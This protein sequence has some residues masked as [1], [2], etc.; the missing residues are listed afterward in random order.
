MFNSRNHNF[1]WDSAVNGGVFGN[2]FAAILG[3]EMLEI[4]N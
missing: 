1:I 4:R 2:L 3:F